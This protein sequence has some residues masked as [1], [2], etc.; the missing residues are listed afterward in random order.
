MQVSSGGMSE[1]WAE[2][3]LLQNNTLERL[4]LLSVHT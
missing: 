3:A 2:Q 4:E 1:G